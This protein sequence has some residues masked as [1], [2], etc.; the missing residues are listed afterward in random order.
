[1][2]VHRVILPLDA[3]FLVIVCTPSGGPRSP[4]VILFAVQLI[5]VTLL[6]SE[7]AP[8]CASPS[9]TPSCSCSSATLSLS[10]RIG[11]LP[12]CPPALP[13]LRAG[14]TALAIMGFWVVAICTAFFSSMVSERRSCGAAS[15]EISALAEMASGHRGGDRSRG[16]GH[17]L[18]PSFAPL[19]SA[20]PFRRGALWCARR[21]P[22]RPAS[23]CSSAPATT[24][25]LR[26]GC[27]S[28]SGPGRQRRPDGLGE[29]GAPPSAGTSVSTMIRWLPGC[30]PAPRTSWCS[31]CRSTVATRAS[32]CSSMGAACS[33][34]A[35][36]SARW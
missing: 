15:T 14:Q 9:G 34:P 11:E 1:M 26:M 22:A 27:P 25:V 30:F 8:A 19:V 23:A 21:A 28:S 6:A 4:L 20:F 33:R 32:S 13:L 24:K 35:F 2:F 5:A 3:I 29:P 18:D 17:S 31:R 16:G 10:G 7:S 36:P 12:R